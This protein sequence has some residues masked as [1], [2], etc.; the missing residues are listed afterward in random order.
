ME[1]PLSP[2]DTMSC[3]VLNHEV[4]AENKINDK[5]SRSLADC[6][7]NGKRLATLVWVFESRNTW[8]QVLKSTYLSFFS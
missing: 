2:D 3:D 8:S 1:A 7:M 4:G 5:I 6:G